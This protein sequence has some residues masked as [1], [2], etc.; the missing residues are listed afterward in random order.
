MIA[1]PA[2]QRDRE[3]GEHQPAPGCPAKAK[4]Q[5]GQPGADQREDGATPRAIPKAAS[6]VSER[7]KDHAEYRTEEI[8]LMP[9]RPGHNQWHENDV[10]DQDSALPIQASGVDLE[11]LRQPAGALPP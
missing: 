4:A 5:R 9:D 6:R 11:H 8:F 1:T 2:H 10:K 7:R 3:Q